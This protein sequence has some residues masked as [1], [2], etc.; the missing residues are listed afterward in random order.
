MTATCA[1]ILLA[2]GRSRRFGGD[3]LLHPL[4]DGTPMAVACA[5]RLYQVLPDCL[6]V[7]GDTRSALAQQLAAEGLRVIANPRARQGMGTSIACGVAAAAGARG[8]LIT[9]ADMPAIPA[10]VIQAL[11]GGLN[12]GA[13]IIAPVCCGRRGHPVGF[14][15]RHG[16]ELLA[17]S[18]DRG[19]RDII[20]A[21]RATLVTLET[22]DCG[23]LHDIDSPDA[24][25]RG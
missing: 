5:R 17:L 21:S 1:G 8:W 19:A 4:A 12:E 10:D 9:L 2:A 15:A 13:D 3:K 7:V 6:A 20:V 16:P 11:A 23:V 24:L 14:A 25:P 18:A 22:A